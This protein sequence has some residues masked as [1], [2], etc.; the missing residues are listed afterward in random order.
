MPNE[1]VAQIDRGVGK[2][3]SRGARGLLIEEAPQHQGTVVSL[4]IPTT[5]KL[6]VAGALWGRRPSSTF[7]MD[8]VA[9]SG[10]EIVVTVVDEASGFGNRDSARPARQRLHNLLNLYPEMR[11]VVD[12]NAVNLLSASF[13]DEFIAR[14]AKEVGVASFFQRVVL[15]NMNDLVRRTMDAVLEQRMQS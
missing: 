8:Y 15:S 7:E 4:T 5:R 9:D 3:P 11:V 12:F 13:A 2:A 1:S 14:L 10:N 6:D